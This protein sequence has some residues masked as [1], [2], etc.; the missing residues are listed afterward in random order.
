VSRWSVSVHDLAGVRKAQVPFQGLALTR[1]LNGAA[2]LGFACDVQSSAAKHLQLGERTVKLHQDTTTRFW[3]R[4]DEPH[5]DNDSDVVV[6]ASDPLAWLA[7]QG[8]WTL[9]DGGFPIAGLATT[10]GP[11]D[12]ATCVHV[13]NVNVA[14]LRGPYPVKL[15]ER[16]TLLETR[17]ALAGSFMVPSVSRTM[18]YEA[19][20]AVLDAITEL[21]EMDDGFWFWCDP[22]Q[23]SGLPVSGF[24]PSLAPPQAQPVIGQFQLRWPAAG[25][26]RPAAKWEFGTG[27][28]N[29]LT[30]F[31]RGFT[32][33]KNTAI[34]TGEGSGPDQAYAVAIDAPSITQMKAILDVSESFTAASADTVGPQ[35]LGLIDPEVAIAYEVTPDASGRSAVPHL[36]DDFDI[37][38]TC[39][40][41]IKHGR[42]ADVDVIVRVHEVTLSISDDGLTDQV[43]SLVLQTIPATEPRSGTLVGNPR[44]GDPSYQI[45]DPNPTLQHWTP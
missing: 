8:I 36:F 20:K 3:G 42:V 17:A 7:K 2:V 38:D 45:S 16:S 9:D 41:T 43:T 11:S 15:S 24:P 34:G 27:T 35:T 18:T 26:D 40:L 1:K 23:G 10:I 37:G 31:K 25:S 5:E 33:P 39:R 29:T 22:K 6:S 32:L 28:L 13:L 44:G 14:C 12:A 19:G 21:A 4:I 30:G